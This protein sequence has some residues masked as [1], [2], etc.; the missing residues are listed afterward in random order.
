LKRLRTAYDA[1][2]PDI[3]KWITEKKATAAFA[4]VKA[5]FA[6]LQNRISTA[7][8]KKDWPEVLRLVGEFR[9]KRAHHFPDTSVTTTASRVTRKPWKSDV[10]MEWPHRALTLLVKWKTKRKRLTRPH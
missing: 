1:V 5:E 6:E 4:E 8:Q 9:A 2:G 3:S 7:E 10:Q